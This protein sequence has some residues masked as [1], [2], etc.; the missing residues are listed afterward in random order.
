MISE[1]W[2]ILCKSRIPTKHMVWIEQHE[3]R[4]EE[5]WKIEE[6]SD[7]EDGE[8]RINYGKQSSRRGRAIEVGKQFSVKMEAEV[9]RQRAKEESDDTCFFTWYIS[10]PCK[11]KAF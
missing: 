8:K 9:C 1:S 3:K 2:F 7:K 6:E 5:K 11:Q 4:E 10:W